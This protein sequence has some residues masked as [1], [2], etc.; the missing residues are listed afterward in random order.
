MNLV[1]ARR[2]V[3]SCFT[4]FSHG[5]QGDPQQRV[6]QLLMHEMFIEFLSH[7]GE[8]ARSSKTA[9]ALK[10]SNTEGYSLAEWGDHWTWDKNCTKLGFMSQEFPG[11]K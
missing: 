4:S 9:P 10:V 5:G 7:A 11:C 3:L 2:S 1:G 8:S 6:N